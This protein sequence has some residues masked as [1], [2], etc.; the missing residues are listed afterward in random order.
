MGAEIHTFFD[1]RAALFLDTL[2]CLLAHEAKHIPSNPTHLNLFGAFGGP[3]AMVAVV[4]LEG[5]VTRVLDATVDLHCSASNN[6]G[7]DIKSP[8]KRDSKI[9]GV[10]H[11]Y[12]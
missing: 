3:S 1:A 7:L 12:R 2:R 10:F 6:D 5:L 11:P 4:L 9:R 8:S